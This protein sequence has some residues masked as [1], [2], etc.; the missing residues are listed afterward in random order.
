MDVN[1]IMQTVTTIGIAFGLKAAG[2]IV[3]W[4][5]GR[6]LIHLAVRLVSASLFTLSL[7]TG[8]ARSSKNIVKPSAPPAFRFLSNTSC[9]GT[10]FR[11]L[12]SWRSKRGFTAE[13]WREPA[14][15]EKRHESKCLSR[16]SE[17]A[18]RARWLI[19]LAVW[20]GLG[21]GT[22]KASSA[23]PG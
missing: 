19:V 20:F 2:A 23:V 17:R 8:E 15:K 21:I 13:F 3:V 18:V 14:A 6:Y 11:P 9:C 1:Q 22:D 12:Q 5:V 10:V 7:A 4:V 16:I